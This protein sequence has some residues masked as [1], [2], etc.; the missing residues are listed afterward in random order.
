[1][2]CTRMEVAPQRNR[3]MPWKVTIGRAIVESFPTQEK[4]DRAAIAA[5]KGIAAKGGQVSLRLKGRKGTIREERTY[6]R[7]AD[8]VGSPG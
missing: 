5:A 2:T 1:M 3:T 6:P 8:P 7:S 4:A